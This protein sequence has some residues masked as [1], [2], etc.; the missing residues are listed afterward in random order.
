[1][2][3]LHAPTPL[4]A[5]SRH[6]FWRFFQT[7]NVGEGDTSDTPV[8]RALSGVAVPMLMAAFWIVTLAGRMPAWNAAGV[9]TLFV[10]YAFCSMGCI[11]AL[12][13]EKLFPERIDFL[14][15]SPLPLQPSVLFLAKLRAVVLFLLMFVVAGS[16]FGTLLLP[17][18]AG[19]HVFWAMLVH[20][21]AVMSAGI[22]ASW[23]VL[24]LEAVVIAITPDRW[25]RHVAPVVQAI[26]VALFLLMFLRV[27]T[28]G[29]R[30]P[31]LLGGSVRGAGWFP[32]LWFESVYEVQM[33]SVAGTAFA[34][35]LAMRALYC[36]PWLCVAVVLTYPLAWAK[37][38]RAALEGVSGRRL[39]DGVDSARAS[40][41]VA[42]CGSARSVPLHP[43]DAVTVESVSRASGR[44]LRCGIG[45]EYCVCR[46]G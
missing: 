9:H 16:I 26:L 18:L 28:V 5:L 11:T 14:I 43:A 6:F 19:R 20:A 12:Q 2:A 24:A 41:G 25:F 42:E 46:V 30:L 44:L 32:P 33:G 34:H 38:R 23:A 45:V 21:T 35:V 15:L 13:W 39:R 10:M 3:D 1:M 29:E 36:L 37:R 31:E 4:Q 7:E 40:H 27:G 8:V 22:A 17:A